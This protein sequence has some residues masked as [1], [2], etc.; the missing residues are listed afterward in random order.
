MVLN[1][2]YMPS[3]LNIITSASIPP[4]NSR[5]I[6]LNGFLVD[7]SLCPY[8]APDTPPTPVLPGAL[9]V[10]ANGDFILLVAQARSCY[11]PWFS[12]PRTLQP[13]HQQTVSALLWN[14][15]RNT[16]MLVQSP[17]LLGWHLTASFSTATLLLIYSQHKSQSETIQTCDS[18][19]LLSTGM[20]TCFRSHLETG[21]NLHKTRRLGSHPSLF[22][23]VC[24]FCSGHTGPSGSS[25]SVSH[26][27]LRLLFSGL[28]CSPTK[29]P[30]SSSPNS[31]LAHTT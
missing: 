22:L 4:F 25:D 18:I 17:L 14:S 5:I 11:Y 29:Y 16:A 28:I 30:C 3:T 8:W 7:I 2:V 13:A 23:L 6:S 1:I 19:L 12:L 10:P 21:Q 26:P 15:T 20:S 24:P 9:H 27:S 31:S